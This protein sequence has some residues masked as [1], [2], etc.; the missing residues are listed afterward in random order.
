MTEFS[1][2]KFYF[3]L[4]QLFN[5]NFYKKKLAMDKLHESKA[6]RE[7]TLQLSWI[8]FTQNAS[9]RFSSVKKWRLPQ[10]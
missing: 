6:E 3:I 8:I 7:L 4:W 1:R 10:P 2:K 9:L 5:F